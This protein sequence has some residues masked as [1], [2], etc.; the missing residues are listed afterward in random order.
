MIHVKTELEVTKEESKKHIV[1]SMSIDDAL[2]MATIFLNLPEMGLSDEWIKATRT[3]AQ[4][5]LNAANRV[6]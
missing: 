4:E 3:L 2:S 1:V 5:L 6:R